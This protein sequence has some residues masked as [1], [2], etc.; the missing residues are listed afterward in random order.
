MLFDVSRLNQCFAFLLCFTFF[1]SLSIF[2]IFFAKNWFFK[3][4]KSK[5]NHVKKK[6]K[7]LSILVYEKKTKNEDL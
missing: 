2:K 1:A 5:I 7:N 3:Q 6:E 4:V